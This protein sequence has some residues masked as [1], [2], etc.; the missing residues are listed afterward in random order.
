MKATKLIEFSFRSIF[1]NRMRSLLTSLGI[2]IGVCSVIVMVGIGEGSQAQITKQIAEQRKTKPGVASLI[3]FARDNQEDSH[4][5]NAEQ[6]EAL[7]QADV[8][9]VQT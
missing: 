6:D 1:R 3:R 5:N 8:L 4:Y 2:I 7:E 9:N